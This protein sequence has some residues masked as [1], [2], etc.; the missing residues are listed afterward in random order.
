M[1]FLTGLL[2]GIALGFFWGVWRATQSF[3][4]RIIERPD[5][6]KEIMDRVSRAAQADQSDAETQTDQEYRTEWHNDICYLY[7]S[8]DNFLAQGSSVV[9]AMQRAE[10]RF[11]GM[12]L[13]FRVKEPKESS[14]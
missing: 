12:K 2:I 11:P 8:K 4:E 9:E 14:Q 6:I 13:E 7:D 1:E 10:Q 3:I 5:E